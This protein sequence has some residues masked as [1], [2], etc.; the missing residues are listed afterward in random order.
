MMPGQG[1]GLMKGD[2]LK[3]VCLK[4]EQWEVRR[5]SVSIF[6]VSL[7]HGP[8]ASGRS[9]AFLLTAFRALL[10][11]CQYEPIRPLVN[12]EDKVLMK[13][14]GHFVLAVERLLNDF[15]KTQTEKGIANHSSHIYFVQSDSSLIYIFLCTACVSWKVVAKYPRC[16][17]SNP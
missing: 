9:L 14:D 4:W 6:P 10:P 15:W 5:E 7:H 17:S 13:F 8:L 11:R 16:F 1:Q 3:L 2:K 12:T